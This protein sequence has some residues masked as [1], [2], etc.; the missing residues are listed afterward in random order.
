VNKNTITAI[1]I[2]VLS[3]LVALYIWT[4]HN[5]FYVVRSSSGEAYEIDRKTGQTWLL[6]GEEKTPMTGPKPVSTYATPRETEIP[7]DQAAKI[8]GTASIYKG[9]LYGK[10]YNGS[11][12][13][14]SR[15][16][17]TVS[18]EEDTNS[19]TRDYSKEVEVSPLTTENFTIALDGSNK[20]KMSN[21]VI[22]QAFGRYSPR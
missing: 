9:E 17:I 11:D 13:S 4:S 1:G 21:W 2:L 5:R 19:W 8:T 12:W 3:A 6:D 18:E 10:F 14:V 16:V 7:S 22:K 20:A 15:I